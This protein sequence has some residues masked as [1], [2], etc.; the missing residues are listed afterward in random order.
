MRFQILSHAGLLVE[1]AGK[2]VI[3]DPW[4]VG[5]CYWR[6][7]WN[8]PPVK[9]ELVASL[10]PDY[11]YLTHVH[12]DHFHGPSL[13]KFRKDVTFLVPKG[14]YDRIREDLHQLGFKNVIE[15]RHGE[16]FEIAPDFRLVSYQ[17]GVFLDSAAMIEGGGVK[18]LNLNDCKHMGG[19]LKQILDNH[20]GIDFVFRSHS[21]ANARLSYQIMDKPTEAVDDISSY[22]ENFAATAVATGAKYAV[23]FASNH[24]HLHDDTF[25]FNQ[26]VQSPA[27]V[28]AYFRRHGIDK[29]E[30]KIMVSGDVWSKDKGF[31][32]S[33]K[34][35][36]SERDAHLRNY[37]AD[38]RGKLE[39]FREQEEK[40]K[41]PLKTVQKYFVRLR[42]ATPWVLR[43]L[44]R[45]Q[46]FTYVLKVDEQRRLIYE[47]DFSK[48][49]VR[50]LTTYN[51]V[52][53]P[54]QIHTSAFIFLRC[55]AYD[56]FSHLSISKRVTYRVQSSRKRYME[57]LNFIFNLYEYD[58]IPL[59]HLF[60]WRSIQTWLLRW[61]ELVLYAQL[62][63]DKV[64]YRRLD[65]K[66]YLQPANGV[67]V[68]ARR[69]SAGS[70]QSV[71][72]RK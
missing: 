34:D 52:D 63:R 44:L 4:L 66:K 70:I 7:W 13:E 14:N 40:V 33:D 9:P 68:D 17:F 39:S 53:N 51:D 30:L 65:L 22:I 48:G 31:Q 69:S 37:L 64:L 28:Q 32:L 58:L 42:D 2:S 59:R 1:H 15:L 18:L 67:I 21:S 26:H 45:K 5:S 19:T 56:I 6:S 23:P 61:R 62:V 43:F 29:P 46:R 38:N 8:Y 71:P 36:F 16:S 3:C 54:I 35:W 60:R 57:A 11:L 72:A 55:I 41:L 27:L 49:E 20:P 12:W 50:E 25:H 10:N 47:L 24:C